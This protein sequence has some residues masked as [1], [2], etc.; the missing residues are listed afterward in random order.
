[1]LTR[2][3]C[4][5]KPNRVVMRVPHY[6]CFANASTA[7]HPVA[8]SSSLEVRNLRAGRALDAAWRKLSTAICRAIFSQ[9]HISCRPLRWITM[10]H[11]AEKQVVLQFCIDSEHV[12]QAALT[13]LP[14]NEKEKNHLLMLRGLLAFGLLRHCLQKRH[15]VDFGLTDRCAPDTAGT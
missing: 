2:L 9:E 5:V 13:Q 7:L 10:L 3:C 1:M 6:A 4:T 12:D 11:E 8:G 15:N 14:L